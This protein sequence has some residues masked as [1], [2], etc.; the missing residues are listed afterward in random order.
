MKHT[1]S[2]LTFHDATALVSQSARSQRSKFLSEAEVLPLL[3]CLGRVLANDVY[4]PEAVPATDNSQMDGF[5][6][7]SQSVS[8]ASYERPVR[9]P[10][11]GS[12]A[13]GDKR[14][15]LEAGGAYEIMTGAAL[16]SGSY[17][18]VLKVEDAV[19][20]ASSAGPVLVV[21]QPLPEGQFVRRRGEDFAKGQHISP[22][23]TRVTPELIMACA[24]LGISELSVLRPVRVAL[25][26]TGKELQHHSEKTLA[27]GTIRDASGP[28]LQAALKDPRYELILHK[29]VLDEPEIFVQELRRC[30]ELGADVVVSTGAVS[31][32]KHDFVKECLLKEGAHLVFHRVAMKPGKPILFAQSA[33]NDVAPVFFGLPGNPVSTLVGWRFFVEPYLREVLGQ[34]LEEPMAASLMHPFPKPSDVT[35]VLKA[36]VED[37][38]GE[39]QVKILEGQGSHQISPLLEANCW[40]LLPNGVDAL[41]A[42]Q[43]ISMFPLRAQDTGLS[44]TKGRA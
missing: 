43:L 29:L 33:Q 31:M 24:A 11:R 2:L 12:I 17:D 9:L 16:Y 42:G 18:T 3:H 20:E 28:Y 36:R 19:I 15:P 39:W 14:V 21:Q 1:E 25:L 8:T 4:S 26:T 27:D 44:I 22:A 23:G 40:A 32:G 10:I 37:F 35:Y 5:V 41:E 38:D 6:V 30:Y 34:P 7:E 13:A